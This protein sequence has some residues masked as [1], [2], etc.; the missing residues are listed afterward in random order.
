MLG[1]DR[2]GR[3][4]LLEFTLLAAGSLFMV[5]DP[6]TLVPVFLSITP[7][8]TPRQ[9]VEMARLACLVAAGVLLFFT[10]IGQGLFQLLGITLPAFK[11]AGSI[12]LLLM[13]LDML[14]ARRSPVK[15][16]VEETD[17]ATAKADVAVT[18]LAVPML[19]GPGAI[20]TVILMRSKAATWLHEGV[21]LLCIIAVCAVSYLIL[22]LA[23]HGVGWVSPIAM[24]I[25][26][27]IMGLLLAA[28][29]IQFMLD[30]I[31]DQK[32]TLF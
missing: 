19:A 26:T 31:R 13:A 24:K 4:D 1:S 22:R 12:V 16:T 2:E 3:M 29:A 6:I 25:V 9:R 32:G 28:I 10:I 30:A 21:L 7:T 5:M 15:E 18:P 27:R 14:R 8:D 11:I 23:A 20:S 17:V